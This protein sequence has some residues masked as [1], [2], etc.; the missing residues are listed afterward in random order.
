M[1]T[2]R[3]NMIE[4]DRQ[5][6]AILDRLSR[7]LDLPRVVVVR[8]ALRWYLLSGLYEEQGYGNLDAYIETVQPLVCTPPARRTKQ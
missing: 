8:Y 6:Q 4:L 1:P 7:H 3:Q 2:M 5:D